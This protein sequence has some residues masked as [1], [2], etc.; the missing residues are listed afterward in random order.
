MTRCTR[1]QRR[2]KKK[3]VVLKSDEWVSRAIVRRARN[4]PRNKSRVEADRRRELK[5]DGSEKNV[6]TKST[7]V[8]VK[9]GEE[10]EL[11]CERETSYT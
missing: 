7:I 5:G 6:R 4:K 10:D 2:R 9:E 1:D 11:I 3:D 8:Q